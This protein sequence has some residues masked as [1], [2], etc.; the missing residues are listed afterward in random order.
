MEIMEAT[1]MSE[2]IAREIESTRPRENLAMPVPAIR[3]APDLFEH[4]RAGIMNLPREAG[5]SALGS[6]SSRLASL[7]HGGVLDGEGHAPAPPGCH[8]ADS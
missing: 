8:W 6:G 3:R 5:T 1:V 4:C 7:E 2:G